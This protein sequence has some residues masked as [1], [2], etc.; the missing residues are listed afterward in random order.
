MTNF[1]RK[2]LILHA[3]TPK[4]APARVAQIITNFWR[5]KQISHAQT[6]EIDPARVAQI[7]TKFRRKTLIYTLKPLKLL[8]HEWNK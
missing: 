8:P 5:E 2:T 6:H 3:K 1:W 7:M 4:F